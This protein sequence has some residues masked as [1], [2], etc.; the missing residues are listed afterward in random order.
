M[1]I[2]HY[3]IYNPKS[4]KGKTEKKIEKIYRKISK[5]HVTYKINLLEISGKE[6]SL[7][8]HCKSD[9]VIVLC[10]GDGTINRFVNRVKGITINCKVYIYKSGSGND[11]VREFKR[12]FFDIT[13]YI[14]KLPNVIVNDNELYKS[15]NG[16]GIG[17][18]AAVCRSKQQYKFAEVNRSYFKISFECIKTFRPYSLEVEIDGEKRLYNDVW[19]FVCNNGR[20]IGGGMK[21]AP[22]ASRIDDNLDIVIIHSISKA[23]LIL[24]FPLIYLGW[25]IFFKKYV[26]YFK[27][28]TFKAKPIGCNIMQ[29]DG[30]VLEYVENVSIN[31]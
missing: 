18:D 27:C 7:V 10:G 8:A 2:L 22:K 29:N 17:I 11:F 25:H 9:D 31:F 5:K 12:K 30:E 28:K 4:Y 23:K 14:K 19:F 16:I 26:D 21:I 15:V 24:I 20:Y 3:F 6:E 1:I 13:E